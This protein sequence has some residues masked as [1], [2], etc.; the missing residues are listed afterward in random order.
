[1][2]RRIRSAR[3]QTQIQNTHTGSVP[4][5]TPLSFHTDTVKPQRLPAICA[6]VSDRTRAERKWQQLPLNGD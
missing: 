3:T 6:I 4:E 2:E 1:M 5:G